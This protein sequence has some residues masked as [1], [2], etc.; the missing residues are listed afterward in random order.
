LILLRRPSSNDAILGDVA[1]TTLFTRF[2]RRLVVEV[3]ATLFEVFLFL[4]PFGRPRFLDAIV[5][6]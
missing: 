6:S 4:E 5:F 1:T 2:F 3:T